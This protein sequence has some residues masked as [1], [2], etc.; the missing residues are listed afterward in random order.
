[1]HVNLLK[2]VQVSVI[3]PA[4]RSAGSGDGGEL[5]EVLPDNH[6]ADDDAPAYPGEET[7]ASTPASAQQT[8]E[9]APPRALPKATIDSLKACTIV[10]SPSDRIVSPTSAQLNSRRKVHLVDAEPLSREGPARL[11][12]H[13][14]RRRWQNLADRVKAWTPET[15][16]SAE[17]TTTSNF[18][19]RTPSGTEGPAAICRS[20]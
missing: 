1:M 20:V 9:I 13:P 18:R 11:L 19:R 10:S 16:P 17:G 3:Q 15:L 7:P 6:M 2:N 4:I 14:V 5:F 12:T 8:S